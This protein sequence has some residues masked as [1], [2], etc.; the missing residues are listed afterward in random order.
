MGW[1]RKLVGD[2]DGGRPDGPRVGGTARVVPASTRERG[3]DPADGTEWGS[4]SPNE[5]AWVALQVTPLAADDGLPVPTEPQEAYVAVPRWVAIVLR[6]AGTNEPLGRSLPARLEVR[7]H[8]DAATRRVVGID[9]E[10]T[11][12]ELEPHRPVAVEHFCE[13]DSILA[14]LRNVASMPRDAIAAGRDLLSTWTDA[15]SALN[16]DAGGGPGGPPSPSW[17]ADEVESMR[18]NAVILAARFQ[19]KPKEREQ[20]RA[21]ALQSLS[22]NAANVAA[23]VL[24]PA[25]FEAM[26]MAQE[27]ST[28]ITAE[29]AATFRSAAGLAD[30]P[31]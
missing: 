4:L 27:V 28:A 2:D 24:A 25:D 6:Q 29:E 10:H 26:V 17:S 14:P 20:A 1:L 7:V 22:L 31:T 11:T 18:R 12:A 19:Q 9:A 5:R 13:T 23:G 16:R 30:G 8:Y 15:A 3:A 21:V